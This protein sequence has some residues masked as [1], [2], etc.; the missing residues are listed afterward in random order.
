MWVLTEALRLEQVG[1]LNAN[2]A[3]PGQEVGG[4]VTGEEGT[5]RSAAL[6]RHLPRGKQLNGEKKKTKLS[7]LV[8]FGIKKK[9]TAHDKV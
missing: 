6:A 3:A 2:M 5:R 7:V 1:L 4:V 8:R 9:I